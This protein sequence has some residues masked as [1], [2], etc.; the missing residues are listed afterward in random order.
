VTAPETTQAA[1]A[2]GIQLTGNA[3]IETF[4]QGL[5]TESAARIS[6]TLEDVSKVL[7]FVKRDGDENPAFQAA[8]RDARRICDAGRVEDAP[9]ILMEALEREERLEEER[10]ERHRRLR[11]R[12]LE[13]AI[14]YDMRALSTDAA[15]TKLRRIAEIIHPNSRKEQT[16]YLFGR[17]SEYQRLGTLRGEIAALHLAISAFSWLAKDAMNG[18]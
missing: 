14:I 17:A 4:V 3:R 1:A 11:L 15:F 10:R 16:Q 7:S 18:Q 2:I 13:E 12:F 6:E 5:N 9:R 8:Q